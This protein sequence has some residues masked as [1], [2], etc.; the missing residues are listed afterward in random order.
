MKKILLVAAM[1][2]L[3]AMS[4]LGIIGCG[5]GGSTS[6]TA[7]YSIMGTWSYN[8][9]GWDEGTITFSGTD[10]SGTYSG[11][12][13]YGY[14]HTGTYTVDGTSVTVTR[15]S[16]DGF[17]WSGSFNDANSMSGTWTAESSSNTWTATRQ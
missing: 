15:D 1:V 16:T 6:P 12:N 5:G 8:M 17:V 10:T 2:L 13:Y 3:L 14:T 9:T 11:I 7:A 4:S